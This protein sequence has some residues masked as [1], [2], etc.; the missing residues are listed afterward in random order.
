MIEEHRLTRRVLILAIEVAERLR[1]PPK[2]RQ[3]RFEPLHTTAFLIEAA[4]LVLTAIA[5]VI[6][7]SFAAADMRIIETLIF[8]VILAFASALVFKVLLTLPF[9]VWPQKWIF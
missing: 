4:G 9:S 6:V 8:G 5:L 1:R 3:R 7:C 2:L